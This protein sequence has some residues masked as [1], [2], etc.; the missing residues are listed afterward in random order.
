MS[1]LPVKKSDSIFDELRN[2]QDRIMKRAYELF[3]GSDGLFG[4]LDNWLTA[5]RELV[6]KPAIEL[7]EK[8]NLFNIDIEMP[9]IDPKDIVIEVTPEELLVKAESVAEKKEEKGEVYTSEFKSG[10]LFRSITFPRKIN[11]ENVKAR[12]KNG[13]LKIS[14]PIAEEAVAKIVEIKA[15]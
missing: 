4:D 9:G 11:T 13:L 2:M 15:A 10:S 3:K 7:R 14:A 12:Y 5:E 6:W 1:E 8:D